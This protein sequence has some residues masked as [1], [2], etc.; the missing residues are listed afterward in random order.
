MLAAVGLYGVVSY[1]VACRTREIGIRIALGARSG[2]VL[3]LFLRNI[4]F[5]L[6]LGIT[7]GIP[8]ALVLARFAQTSLYGVGS[9]DLMTALFAVFVLGG[10]ALCASYFPVRRA[11]KADR[12]DGH[13]R[14][15]RGAGCST[16]WQR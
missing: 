1:S 6:A 12:Q 9:N 4:L 8:L 11:A 16:P 10:V 7:V 13:G 15:S 2:E 5:L 3:I 14:C